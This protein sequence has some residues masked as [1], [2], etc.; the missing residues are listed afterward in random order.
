MKNKKNFLFALIGA[1]TLVL[2]A[3]VGFAAWTI[4]TQNESNKKSINVSADGMVNDNRITIDTTNSKFKDEKGLS[5]VGKK[6]DETYNWL[7][8]NPEDTTDN[9][10]LTFHL[11]VTSQV[12]NL[13]LKVTGSIVDT[14]TTS[15]KNGAFDQLVADNLITKPTSISGSLSATK[16]DTKKYSADL[17]LDFGWGAEFGKVNPYKYY[18]NQAYTPDLGNSASTNLKKLDS[19]KNYLNL[20]FS[21]TVSVA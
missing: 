10:S 9:L 4:G 20:E 2:S 12:E 1:G 6:T 19:I 17:T 11:E 5:F 18:N 7:S 14:N 15:E 13:N 8:I 16:D 3:G 21:Y